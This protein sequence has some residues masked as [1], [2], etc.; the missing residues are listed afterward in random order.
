MVAL[1]AM[2]IV[3]RMTQTT[4]GLETGLLLGWIVFLPV[5]FVLRRNY[6]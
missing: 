1:L 5:L 6:I 2:L 4:L 3:T